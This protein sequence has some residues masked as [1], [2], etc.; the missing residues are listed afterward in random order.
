MYFFD[1]WAK[2]IVAG[3]LL[4]ARPLHPYPEWTMTTAEDY[5]RIYPEQKALFQKRV[6]ADSIGRDARHEL[7]DEWYCE[8]C[9]HQEPA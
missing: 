4:T 6:P 5:F 2:K 7:W 3:D 9:L 8:P 1:L